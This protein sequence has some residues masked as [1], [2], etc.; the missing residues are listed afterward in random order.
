MSK[1]EV[2]DTFDIDKFYRYFVPFETIE[3][4]KKQPDNYSFCEC[5]HMRDI[6]KKNMK[7]NIFL[8]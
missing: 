8:M 4:M 1:E 7:R 6:A 2:G 3:E 5:S